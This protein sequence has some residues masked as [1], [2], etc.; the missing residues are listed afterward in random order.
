MADEVQ[1]CQVSHDAYFTAKKYAFQLQVCD[2]LSP[3]RKSEQ[4][5]VPWRLKLEQ[6]SDEMPVKKASQAL[7]MLRRNIAACS[8]STE[9]LAYNSLVRP[10]LEYASTVWDPH[11]DGL[12]FFMEAVQIWA[13]GFVKSNYS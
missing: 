2:E 4:L 3:T 1:L 9:E 5:S 8:R 13:A 11:E 12:I 10:R 7:G 6:T